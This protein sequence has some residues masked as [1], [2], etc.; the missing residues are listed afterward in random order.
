MRS[1]AAAFV[2]R[3]YKEHASKEASANEN[4]SEKGDGDCF[5]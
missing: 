2:R 3:G 4:Y 5:K 1:I